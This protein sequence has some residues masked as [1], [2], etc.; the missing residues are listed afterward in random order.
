MER[1]VDL[2][3]NRYVDQIS[4][5]IRALEPKIWPEIKVDQ[6]TDESAD[7]T[8]GTCR[9]TLIMHRDGTTPS[10]FTLTLL[11]GEEEQHPD[12]MGIGAGDADVVDMLAQPIAALLAGRGEERA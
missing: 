6:L 12:A 4:D 5:R 11:A 7:W 1:G 9:A 10:H 8:R 2:D 3:F